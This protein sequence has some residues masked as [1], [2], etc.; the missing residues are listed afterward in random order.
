MHKYLPFYKLCKNI[1]YM[2]M[3]RMWAWIINRTPVLSGVSASADPHLN[4]GAS[5]D[6]PSSWAIF[7]P[8]RRS[9]MHRSWSRRSD[10][11]LKQLLDLRQTAGKFAITTWQGPFFHVRN[12]TSRDQ[13]VTVIILLL[14]QIVFSGSWRRLFKSARL[15]KRLFWEVTTI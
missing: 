6:R 3:Q 5:T 4:F 2:L 13:V 8:V 15:S 14:P 9:S 7:H 11:R 1:Q 10:G 12:F